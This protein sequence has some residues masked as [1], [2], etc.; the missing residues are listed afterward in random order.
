MTQ[1]NPS[2]EASRQLSSGTEIRSKINK[3]SWGSLTSRRTED[4][5]WNLS[6]GRQVFDVSYLTKWEITE[7]LSDE[8]IE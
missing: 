7:P 2:I 5:G 3:K 1:K 8:D 6:N 4:D